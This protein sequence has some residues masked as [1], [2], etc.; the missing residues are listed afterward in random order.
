VK[1]LK[2]LEGKTALV[3]G[4]SRGI[5]SGIALRLASEGALVAVHYGSKKATAEQV[6]QQIKENGGKAFA[7][8]ADLRTL[9]GVNKLTDTF[10][11]EIKQRTGSQKFDILV[12]NAGIGT[13]QTLEETTE[14]AFDEIFAIN[15]KAPFFLVQQ[16][17]STLRDGGRIINISSGVTRIPF[18]HIMSYNM[19]KGALNTFTMHLAHLLGP[20]NITVNA[21]LP[22]IIDTDVNA[23]WLHTPEGQATAKS[24]AALG[25]TGDISDIADVVAFL[26]SND[27]RFVTGDTIDATGGGH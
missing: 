10:A 2:R 21:V 6:V 4:A 15:V 5:G 26:A 17:L 22:G 20:R 25:R 16:L 9:A 12:N 8:G 1:N 18:P 19:T 14:E 3:T 13:S 11:E 23:S 24:I 27:S 7:I